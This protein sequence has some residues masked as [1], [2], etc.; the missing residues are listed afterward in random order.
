MM[1]LSTSRPMSSVPKGCARLGA[2]RRISGWIPSGSYGARTG[3]KTAVSTITTSIAAD[4]APSG[5]RFSVSQRS[6]PRLMVVISGASNLVTR[7]TGTVAI[8]RSRV[9]DARIQ[10]RVC[11]IDDQV[12]RDERRGDQHDVGMHDRIVA[13]QDGLDGEQSHAGQREDRLHDKRG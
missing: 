3:A 8:S 4:A 2:E 10:P 6:R 7:V 11:Q 9:A 13:I 12:Q 5:F 1:R